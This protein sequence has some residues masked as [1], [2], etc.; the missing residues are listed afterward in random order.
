MSIARGPKH[1]ESDEEFFRAIVF[2]EEERSRF[3]AAAWDSS[4]RWF[5]SPNVVCFEKYR[6]A[7]ATTVPPNSA[8]VVVRPAIFQRAPPR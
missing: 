1:S 7:Q 3:T 2:P 5:A 4:F 6:G 8:G